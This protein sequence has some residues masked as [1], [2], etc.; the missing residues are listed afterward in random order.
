MLQPQSQHG[1]RGRLEGAAG[2]TRAPA[3]QG[4]PARPATPCLTQASTSR[5]RRAAAEP[6]AGVSL[7]RA[8]LLPGAWRGAGR[9]KAGSA[10]LVRHAA[11]SLLLLAAA[12][13]TRVLVAEKID[14]E[15]KP[16]LSHGRGRGRAVMASGGRTPPRHS[17]SRGD[18]AG[19]PQSVV[20]KCV[21]FLYVKSP[22]GFK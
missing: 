16:L 22:C 5:W 13:R 14:S 19:A 21:G 9:H 4:A 1:R 20:K 6:R 7:A 10:V 3:A 15:E 12:G 8:A 18:G 2:S 11:L 17:A